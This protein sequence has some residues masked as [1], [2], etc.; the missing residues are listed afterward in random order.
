LL[1]P[2]EKRWRYLGVRIAIFLDDGWG[3]DKDRDTY[4]CSHT[5]NVVKNDLAQAGFIS[6][7]DKS[8]WTPCQSITWIGILWHTHNG[9]I[10]LT[11][12]DL[13]KFAQP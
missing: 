3:I 6:N 1:K 2:V 4:A 7:D 5:S 13:T 9:T 8:V 12:T 11:S 10:E